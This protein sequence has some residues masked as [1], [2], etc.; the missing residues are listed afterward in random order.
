[1][2]FKNGISKG[3]V[4]K[5]TLTIKRYNILL[6]SHTNEPFSFTRENTPFKGIFLKFDETICV[7][8][9]QVF[10]LFGILLYKDDC[11]FV[12]FYNNLIYIS[13]KKDGRYIN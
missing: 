5:D 10:Q 12:M 2:L 6:K 4:Y 1:M 7:D 13:R 11:N 3:N 9:V 8:D